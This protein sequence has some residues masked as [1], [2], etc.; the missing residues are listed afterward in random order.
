MF[1]YI[2]PLTF[3]IHLFSSPFFFSQQK[4]NDFDLFMLFT[5]N[6]LLNGL[7]NNREGIMTYP[8]V[9][10]ICNNLSHNDSLREIHVPDVSAIEILNQSSS[11][12]K[13]HG[14]MS[15][16]AGE[17]M[18]AYEDSKAEVMLVSCMIPSSIGF[19]FGLIPTFVL[20]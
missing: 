6:Y 11:E 5:A 7:P 14:E 8:W 12:E 15:M 4:G 3:K 20:F 13:Q 17:F 18:L 16:C 2:F 19:G 9:H 10:A 1:L